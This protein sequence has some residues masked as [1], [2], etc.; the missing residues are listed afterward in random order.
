MTTIA[1]A[2][3]MRRLLVA[4][5]LF[6][7][8]TAMAA[9][10]PS[11]PPAAP[12]AA[13]ADADAPQQVL[14]LLSMPAAHFRADG[15][16]SGGYADA[17]GVAARRRVARALARANGLS[18]ATQWPMPLLGVDCYVLD[19]P[20]PRRPDE[21]AA[22]LAQD[23]RVA[24]AQA[25]NTFRPLG[26]DDP[27]FALQP[28]ARDWQLAELHAVATG[29]D[30]RVAVVDSGVQ[31][32]HPDLI[33]QIAGNADFVAGPAPAVADRAAPAVA[34][35]HGTAVAGI[36]AARADNPIG[37]AGIA[38]QARLLTLRGCWQTPAFDTL[39]NTLSLS[40]ALQAAIERDA[41][42]INLSLGGP[43]DRLVRALVEAAQ[44][45]G[46]SVVAAVNRAAP[47][48]GFPA[49]LRGVVA[50]LDQ[51]APDVPSGT[52]LAPGTDVPTT[53]PGSRWAI[54]S[55]A[56]YAAAHVSGL[57]ALMLEAR[58]RGTRPHDAIAG[59]LVVRAD[60]RIDACASLARSAAGCVCGCG[61]EPVTESIARH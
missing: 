44:V 25:M 20:S 41:Q 54:V 16:Y 58:A 35:L 61:T 24:W 27:L 14:V 50:V 38:P 15:N 4:A 30:V 3:W 5:A 8:G 47:Q 34:E 19:V 9:P 22:Q 56:S 7:L 36:I 57:L 60:G 18:L 2:R 13:V 26:H 55:G 43:P 48:G 33:G 23:P 31:Q 29:R 10:P 42:V 53:V 59:D 40:L 39:C 45:R 52:V 46:I 28:A 49:A 1:I 32:D 37:I 51:P 17:T 21:V 6:S 12:P 11:T